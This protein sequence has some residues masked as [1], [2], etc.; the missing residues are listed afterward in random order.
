[1][2]GI[3]R[4]SFLIPR[5]TRETLYLSMVRPILDYG[6]VVLDNMKLYLKQRL[7]SI[8]RRAAVICTDAFARTPTINLLKE[9]GWSSLDDR[10]KYLRLSIF[11]K[12]VN[13]KAPSYLC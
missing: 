12:M 6:S 13:K 1:M 2:N 4:I 11:N 10:R 3:K 9:L 7:E 5:C 8:Q